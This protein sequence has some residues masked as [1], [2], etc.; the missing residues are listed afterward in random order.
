VRRV[1]SLPSG[2]RAFLLPSLLWG[3][4]NIASSF[5]DT[6]IREIGTMRNIIWDSWLDEPHGQNIG[7]GLEHLRF[8]KSA[9][10]VIL[11]SQSGLGFEAYFYVHPD[12]FHA[13]GNLD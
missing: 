4:G 3:L 1:C 6:N 11:M 13:S 10:M 5:W 8:T 9:P 2:K 12:I 7:R